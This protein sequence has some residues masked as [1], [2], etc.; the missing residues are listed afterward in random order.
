MATVEYN[1]TMPGDVYCMKSDFVAPIETADWTPAYS[2]RF[3]FKDPKTGKDVERWNII[4]KSIRND[5]CQNLFTFTA[6]SRHYYDGGTAKLSQK[7]YFEQMD[8]NYCL[9]RNMAN[10]RTEKPVNNIYMTDVEY[11]FENLDKETEPSVVHL[12]TMLNEGEFPQTATRTIT[13][14]VVNR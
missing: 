12:T 7:P 11:D 6:A 1:M 4:N 3:R 10:Y 9:T 8:K 2:H 13:A 5:K 14:R